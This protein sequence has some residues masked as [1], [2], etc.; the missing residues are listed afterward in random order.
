MLEVLF[1]LLSKFKIFVNGFV[2]S[3]V[4]KFD[5]MFVVLMC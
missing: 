1:V 2:F 3:W 5:M 4:K